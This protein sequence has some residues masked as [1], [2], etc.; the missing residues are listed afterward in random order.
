MY[1]YIYK[2]TNLI[3]HKIY[4]GQHKSQVFDSNY[5]GSGK[6]IKLA[7]QKYGPENFK[8]ELIEWC[9]TFEEINKREEYYIEHYNSRNEKVGYNIKPG[10][11]QAPMDERTKEKIRLNAKTNPNFGMKGKKVSE[12]CKKVNSIIHKGVSPVNKGKKMSEEQRQKCIKSHLGQKAWNKNLT[13]TDI[14]KQR[15]G[16]SCSNRKWMNNGSIESCVPERKIEEYLSK[17]WKFGRLNKNKKE[18]N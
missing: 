3:N 14:W 17:N 15:I 11:I 2:I 5:K 1:G 10:G 16:Q 13:L 18:K 6:V 8:I 4:I 7:F 12:L 9:E